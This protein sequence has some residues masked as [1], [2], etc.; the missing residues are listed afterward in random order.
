[1]KCSVPDCDND[2][3]VAYNEATGHICDDCLQGVKL[4]QVDHPG[5]AVDD[6]VRV[7][8]CPKGEK[9]KPWIDLDQF[10]NIIQHTYELGSKDTFREGMTIFYKHTNDKI[11]EIVIEQVLN[12]GSARFYIDGEE[13]NLNYEDTGIYNKDKRWV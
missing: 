4:I 8:A 13:V 10:F 12:D 9:E 6:I 1:M 11:I 2:N 3:C 5:I 7:L